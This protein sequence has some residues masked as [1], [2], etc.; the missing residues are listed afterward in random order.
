M[1][2]NIKNERFFT[3]PESISAC[4]NGSNV[5]ISVKDIEQV[6]DFVCRCKGVFEIYLEDGYYVKPKI[7][8]V[9]INGCGQIHIVTNDVFVELL[10]EL[11][12]FL[13]NNNIVL[14]AQLPD[15]Q[16]IVIAPAEKQ[17]DE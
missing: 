8:V 6:E 5:V 7:G 13:I 11:P 16:C 3:I 9:G 14:D 2:F 10:R 15:V 1:E 4:M 12:N 17:N